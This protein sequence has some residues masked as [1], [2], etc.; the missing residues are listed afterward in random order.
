MSFNYVES[1]EA[2]DA[3][4]KIYFYQ[5]SRSFSDRFDARHTV[6]RRR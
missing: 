2:F 4:Q 1:I 6:S 3:D 5:L